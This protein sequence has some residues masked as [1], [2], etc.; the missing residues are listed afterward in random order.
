MRVRFGVDGA[1]ES[2]LSVPV[3]S[4]DKEPGVEFGSTESNVSVVEL[5]K[6]E[7][8]EVASEYILPAFLTSLFPLASLTNRTPAIITSLSTFVSLFP[9]ATLSS[10]GILVDDDVEAVGP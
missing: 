6:S 10:A 2:A 3:E 7:R 1:T 4:R 5:A 9:D 8:F